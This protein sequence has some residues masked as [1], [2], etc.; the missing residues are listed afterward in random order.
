MCQ[1][2]FSMVTKAP[3][4]RKAILEGSI[5]ISLTASFDPITRQIS[6]SVPRCCNRLATT[7]EVLIAMAP[8]MLYE[9]QGPTQ[10]DEHGQVV[11]HRLVPHHNK[12]V[13]GLQS[14]TNQEV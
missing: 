10:A 11:R 5:N 6:A 3:S 7:S 8:V 4:T 9:R 1:G 2:P 12:G 14:R 13:Y